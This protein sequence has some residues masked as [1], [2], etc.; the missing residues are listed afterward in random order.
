MGR[1]IGSVLTAS[2]VAVLSVCLSGCVSHLYPDFPEDRISMPHFDVERSRFVS[3][4]GAELGLTVWGGELVDPDHVVVGIHGMNDYANAFHMAGPWWAEHGVRT[5]AYDQRGFGRSPHHGRWPN[6]D[7]MREDLRTIVRAA[8]SEHPDAVLTVVGISMGGAVAMS[9]FGGEGAP[10]IDRLILSGP[11]LR[12]MG[13]I[14]FYQK[15]ALQLATRVR[16]GWIVT[17]PRRFVRIEPSD[18]VE[19]LQRTW[20]DPLMQ[21]ENRIDQVFGVAQLMESAHQSAAR[22]PEQ[23]LLLY[24]ARDYV[25]PPAG[26]ERT[27]RVL[28]EHVRTAY[29]E[30]GYHMLMR[31]LQ[32][33]NVWRDQLAFMIDPQAELPSGAPQLP[34]LREN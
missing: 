32:A 23:T 15:I 28:P 3:F 21:R 8:R 2:I 10:D 17:P 22:L 27:A 33:E 26:V 16:P 34:W 20:S 6:E 4:D 24:G 31:D 13:A 30:N 25:I 19:M 29:Y 14:P 11:G 5:Y 9:T 7:V 12:G 1:P 18:N